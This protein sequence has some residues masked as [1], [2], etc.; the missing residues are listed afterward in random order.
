M[1]F[2]GIIQDVVSFTPLGP[3]FSVVAY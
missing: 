2:Q 1:V 3:P